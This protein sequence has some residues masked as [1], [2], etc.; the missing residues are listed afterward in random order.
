MRSRCGALASSDVVVMSYG[1][2]NDWI[3]PSRARPAQSCREDKRFL[4]LHI[5]N[6]KLRFPQRSVYTHVCFTFHLVRI[7]ISTQVEDG[8]SMLWMKPPKDKG[9]L[10]GTGIKVLWHGMAKRQRW[11]RIQAA[12]LDCNDVLRYWRWT[13]S[14][15]K[16]WE[17]GRSSQ[18]IDYW[19]LIFTES[20]YII[21]IMY[22][23]HHTGIYI[24]YWFSV[25]EGIT[26]CIALI[27]RSHM[28]GMHDWLDQVAN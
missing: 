2:D 14:L 12:S 23:V 7:D 21:V 18:R 9:G 24:E 6:F 27:Y 3:N 28:S 19:S 25:M 4:I 11:S 5:K 13:S 1:K 16:L 26:E 10:K 17:A 20:V 15:W 22:F 8:S